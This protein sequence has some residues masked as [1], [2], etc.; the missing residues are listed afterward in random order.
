MQKYIRERLITSINKKISL[1][2][3]V[4]PGN[5]NSKKKKGSLIDKRLTSNFFTKHRAALQYR[6]DH[7]KL[8][9]KTAIFNYSQALSVDS[10]NLY[11]GTK[12]DILRRFSESPFQQPSPS[13]AIIIE[14]SPILR[15]DFKYATFLMFAQKAYAHII[16]LGKDYG[17]IDVICDK[18]FTNSLKIQTRDSRGNGNI[19]EF[20]GNSVFP[21][22]FNEIR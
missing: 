7:A 18:Y 22:D 14:L 15:L 6:K 16:D 19:M 13:S 4:L 21:K 1:N 8:L 5:E 12:S 17:R 9:F 11:H 2:H 20:H 10:T 3:F